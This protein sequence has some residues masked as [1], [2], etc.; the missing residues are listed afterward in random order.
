MVIQ[1]IKISLYSPYVYSFHLFFISFASIRSLLFLS[2]IVS[3]FGWNK[4]S[5][6]F[7]KFLEEISSL[8]LSVVVLH[9]FDCSLR[10]AFL[11]VLAVLWNS[12]FSCVSLSLSPLLFASLLP[13]AICKAS[14]NHFAFLRFFPH[15]DGF[16]C[17][18]RYGIMELCPLVTRSNLLTLFFAST[19]YS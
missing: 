10:K 13:S 5:F 18:L 14:S 6:D 17:C 3:I 16:L 15:W 4:C 9:S 19:V 2:F 12:T 7:S 8:T 1:V 11:S